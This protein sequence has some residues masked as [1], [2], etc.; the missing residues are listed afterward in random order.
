MD[1]INANPYNVNMIGRQQTSSETDYVKDGNLY[2]GSNSPSVMVESKSNIADLLELDIYA[3]GTIFFT[4]GMQNM[5][6][7]SAA[8]EIETIIEEAGS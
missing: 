5:W 4:A 7:L 6:Q 3:P 1:V 8:G 2:R